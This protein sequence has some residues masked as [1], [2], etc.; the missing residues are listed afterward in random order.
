ME[1]KGRI[2]DLPLS[3]QEEILAR[4]R[5]IPVFEG[6][7]D[8]NRHCVM[9][10]VLIHA[11]PGDILVTVDEPQPS[12]W[13]MFQG[14]VRVEKLELNDTKSSIATFSG[15]ETFGE[16]P[17]M[18]ST[19]R[20]RSSVQCVA[21][22]ASE[23]LRMDE[24][25]FWQLIVS[26]P[27]VRQKILGNLAQ[28]M[29]YYQSLLL[30]REKLISL[31]TLSAG[32]MHELNN[33]GAAAQRAASQLR[34]NLTRLQEMALRHCRTD[35]QP[36]ELD[37]MAELQEFALHAPK[38]P[39]M[40]SMDQADA[41][42]SLATWLE[43]AGVDDAWR[44]SPMLV[45]IGLSEDRLECTRTCCRPGILS[46]SLHWLEAL[47][48]SLQLVGV[49][50]ESISRVTDLVMAVKRYS[51]ADKAG[52]KDIDVRESLHSTMVILAHKM[53]HKQIQLEKQFAP[54]LPL[55]E[56]RAAGLNQVWTNL[57]DNAIDAVAQQGHIRVRTWQ[58]GGDICVAIADD[59]MGIDPENQVHVFEPFFT[60]KP[61]GVGTG[62]GLNI[63]HRIVVTDF[64]GDIQLMSK[65]GN[66]EFIVRLPIKRQAVTPE[67]QATESI[68]SS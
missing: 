13:A 28:R 5:Q 57:L 38:Q 37:C 20:R 39:P 62:L 46:D 6:L 63:A 29:E 48:S 18:L 11:A 67:T 12:F 31:G 60:T 25:S 59:G 66:T 64:G 27:S 10:A 32:L 8:E 65:P 55:L 58:D 21:T 53:R 33:P 17:L 42:D 45:S 35:F 47:V 16:I 44:L 52:A 22:T 51:Y 43:K 34:E 1:I 41:E 4:L 36:Q 40:S 23:L 61:V 50:E 68:K 54:D 7:T 2:A 15:S 9:D 56:A 14:N 49:V 19:T 24:E 3:E 26:C 30:Q